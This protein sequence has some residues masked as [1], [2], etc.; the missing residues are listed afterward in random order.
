MSIRP[1]QETKDAITAAGYGDLIDELV[2]TLRDLWAR[3]GQWSSRSELD[4]IGDVG[5][6]VMWSEGLHIEP[7][8]DDDGAYIRVWEPTSDETA[9][10]DVD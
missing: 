8:D 1:S 3:A 7:N 6:E 5:R 2:T 4:A 9:S 10:P